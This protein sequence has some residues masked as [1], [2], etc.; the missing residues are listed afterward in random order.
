MRLKI[1]IG[2]ALSLLFLSGCGWQRGPDTRAT[3]IVESGVSPIG[4]KEAVWLAAPRPGLSAAGKDY[5]FV[6]P[7]TVNRDG[8][9]RSY[10]WFAIGT[11][12][13]RHLMG[14]PKPTLQTIVL[15]VDG[16][17]M[18]FDLTPWDKSANSSPY[19]LSIASY[20]SYAARVTDSQ[21]R[22]LAI[23]GTVQAYVTDA[24]DRSPIYNIVKGDPAKWLI[25]R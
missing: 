2:A 5:L 23:A 15:L 6:G 17:P 8:A 18:T 10:L 24:N 21:I 22:Q 11:T 16:I 20:S 9:H 3:D 12:I 13:D 1:C 14:T 19:P 25:E 4:S 7:M